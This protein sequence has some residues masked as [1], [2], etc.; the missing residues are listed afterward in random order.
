M[1][2][3]LR[4]LVQLL[5]FCFWDWTWSPAKPLRDTLLQEVSSEK[6]VDRKNTRRSY[7]ARWFEQAVKIPSSI[8]TILVL[9]IVSYFLQHFSSSKGSNKAHSIDFERLLQSKHPCLLCLLSVLK[10][11]LTNYDV[12]KPVLTILRPFHEPFRLYGEEKGPFSTSNISAMFWWLA[13]I[14]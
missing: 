7:T 6:F 4:H 10:G 3:Q 1:A 11:K 8:N 12:T 13:E 5:C 14:M 2:L 9:T